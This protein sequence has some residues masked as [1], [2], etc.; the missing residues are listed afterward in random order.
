MPFGVSVHEEAD[1]AVRVGRRFGI[2][3]QYIRAM[4]VAVDG[5]PGDR[6]VATRDGADVGDVLHSGIVLAF[7]GAGVPGGDVLAVRLKLAG[8]LGVGP[9]GFE[10][11]GRLDLYSGRGWDT[12]ILFFIARLLNY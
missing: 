9:G 4:I 2:E 1:A 7:A 12:W 5:R 8:V 11:D 10:V 6:P 3:F